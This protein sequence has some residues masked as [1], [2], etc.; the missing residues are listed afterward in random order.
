MTTD[1]R[2]PPIDPAVLESI[3]AFAGLE[4]TARAAVLGAAQ[5]RRVVTGAEVFGQGE[6]AQSFFVLLE[7][8][9][10]VAKLT[11]EGHQMT[12]RYIGPGES[13]GCVAVCGGLDYPA[14][15]MAVEESEVLA[16]TR[17]QTQDLAGRFPRIA[18]NVM[19]IMGGRIEDMQTRLGE[20]THERVERRIAR[21]LIRLAA[22]A[23]RREAEGVVIDFPLSRQDL[24][25]YAG[26]TLSTVSRTMSRWEEDGIVALGRQRVVIRRPHA[27]VAIADDL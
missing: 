26:T 6:P 24:A 8:R 21:A 4:P 20:V 9:L 1:L 16:W 15:A 18:M 2:R 27:L 23:G 11:P 19:R 3:E 14:G 5:R 22:Q 7:G 13:F 25:E 10:R 17:A 12:V